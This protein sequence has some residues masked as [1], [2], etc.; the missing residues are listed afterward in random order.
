M[1]ALLG[2]LGFLVPFAGS[3]RPSYWGD[4]AASVMSAERS[5]P[6]LVAML[7]NVDAVHG[8]YYLGLHFWIE[9]FGASELSTRLPSAIAVGVATAGTFVLARR[10]V[11]TSVA[12][13]SAL[14]FLMLP[15]VTNM[16][17]EARSA[18]IATAVVVWLAVLLLHILRTSRTSTTATRIGLW[19]G[20][21]ALLALGIYLFLYVLLLI[22]VFALFVWLWTPWRPDRRARIRSW[23]LASTAGVALATPVIIEALNQ[24]EQIAFI[25]RR[26]PTS[27]LTAAVNQWFGNPSLAIAA[28]AL[29]LLAVVLVYAGRGRLAATAQ[30]RAALSVALAWMLVPSATLLIGTQLISPMYSMRYLS[31]CT[32]A[33]A[34]AVGLG[35]ARLRPFWAQT[36]VLMLIALLMAPTYVAQRGPFGKNE[37]SDWRQAAAVV[38]AGALPGDAVVFDESVRPS[39]KPRLALHLYPAAFQGLRDITLSRP[40]DATPGLW[41]LTVPLDWVTERLTGTDRVWVLQYLGSGQNT[42]GTDIRTLQSLGFTVM[43]TTTVNR[44]LIIELAR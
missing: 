15:R 42:S 13:V 6:K 17:A 44:T 25:G 14:V 2:T 19:A 9:L 30:D 12:T 28:W 38:Q 24:R 4:E 40:F 27:V 36:G 21:S 11:S 35:I 43:A 7:G 33:V 16:G 29:V 8:A 10:L 34:I 37:G 32:P 5:I 26:P 18:A 3:W 39:R 22:P 23:A 20:Y 31:I 41:D 1:P